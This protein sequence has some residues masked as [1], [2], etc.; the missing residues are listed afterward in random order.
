M[1]PDEEKRIALLEN[2]IRLLQAEVRELTGKL[3]DATKHQVDNYLN[4]KLLT[5]GGV[6]GVI[7]AMVAALVTFFVTASKADAVAATYKEATTKLL[8]ISGE[9]ATANAKAT[10]AAAAAESSKA[11][12]VQ[13]EKSAE[14]AK[15]KL[16]NFAGETAKELAKDDSFRKEIVQSANSDLKNL[17]KD[18]QELRDDTV[19]R[20]LR[21][22]C[23][24][25]KC[26]KPNDFQTHY[27]LI[28]DLHIDGWMS[29]NRT[30][31]CDRLLAHSLSV[32][33][34]ETP[35]KGR[36]IEMLNGKDAGKEDPAKQ[37]SGK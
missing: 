6:G 7:G 34:T 5:W 19:I 14:E 9:V 15:Q 20:F 16:V 31:S 30:L 12:I 36:E 25:K 17:R 13:A 2:T 27:L 21:E 4:T 29:V 23:S 24:V 28:P 1:T 8:Q 32:D 10:E 11:K 26:A 37:G 22:H 3:P 33:T 35:P 18:L